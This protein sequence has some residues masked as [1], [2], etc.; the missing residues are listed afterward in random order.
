M[1]ALV[2]ARSQPGLHL[3]SCAPELLVQKGC[4]LKTHSKAAIGVGIG[5]GMG[6]VE[7][8]AEGLPFLLSPIVTASIFVGS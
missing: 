7:G 5:G 3:P 6:E 1:R 4:H 8:S 2:A